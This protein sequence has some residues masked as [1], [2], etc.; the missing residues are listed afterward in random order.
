MQLL[1]LIAHEKLT[2][3]VLYIWYRNLDDKEA[4][5]FQV[6]NFSLFLVTLLRFERVVPRS[7]FGTLYCN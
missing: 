3:R 7:N 5:I 6:V 2:I 4:I 1:N